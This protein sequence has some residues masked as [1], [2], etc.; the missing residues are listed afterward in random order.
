MLEVGQKAPDF[1]LADQDGKLHTLSAE[2]GK[3]VLLYFYPKD[4]TPGCTMEAC[5]LRDKFP[6]FDKLNATIFGV[7]TDA[8]KS[9]GKFAVKYRLPFTILADEEKKVVEIY[10]VWGLKTFM[11]HKFM[12]TKRW[13]FLIDPKG[14]IA[15]IYEDVKPTKHTIEVLKDLEKLNTK[16]EKLNK[17]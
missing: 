9:H 15:K 7:S 16:K 14:V 12:G 1:T 10:G 13:S 3:W 6:K 8:V 17:T 5:S 4:D 2:Q 11:G